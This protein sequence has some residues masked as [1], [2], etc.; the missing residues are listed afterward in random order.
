MNFC[1]KSVLP[2]TSKKKIRVIIGK[3]WVKDNNNRTKNDP[4]ICET[5]MICSF[6]RIRF[7][8]LNPNPSVR[9]QVLVLDKTC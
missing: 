2:N 1:C 5:S 7:A 6:H 9:I 8:L 4:M 3:F